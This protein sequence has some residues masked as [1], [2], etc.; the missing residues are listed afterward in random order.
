MQI[1][2]LFAH[3]LTLSLCL[4]PAHSLIIM[5]L[6]VVGCRVQSVQK[7]HFI[8]FFF[9]SKFIYLNVIHPQQQQEQLPSTTT[10][11]TSAAT[12]HMYDV[13]QVKYERSSDSIHPM[14]PTDRANQLRNQKSQR[15]NDIPLIKLKQHFSGKICVALRDLKWVR[16][17]VLPDA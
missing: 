14:Q 9:C 16:V 10:A 11:T 17:S 4:S 8:S 15:T 3:S 12:K 6:L 1:W 13:V 2:S 7:Y 5:M